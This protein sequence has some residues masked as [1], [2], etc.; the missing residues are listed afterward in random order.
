MMKVGNWDILEWDDMIWNDS[1]I[2]NLILKIVCNV[3]QGGAS[4]VH[5]E[6]A[7]L[8]TCL[9]LL[10]CARRFALLYACMQEGRKEGRKQ[11]AKR[12]HHVDKCPE[13]RH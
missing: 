12:D 7:R 11:L 5:T 1:T 6:F 8:Y 3:Q 9:D 13:G 4:A 10:G 2:L